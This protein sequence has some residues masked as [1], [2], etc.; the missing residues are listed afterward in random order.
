[1]SQEAENSANSSKDTGANQSVPKA[2]WR[3]KLLLLCV[4]TILSMLLAEGV[5][6]IA[7][8]GFPGFSVPQIEH[9]PA[10]GVGF[11]MIP[12]QQGFTFSSPVVVNSDGFRGPEIRERGSVDLRILCLGDSIT[13][14][15][16]VD[17]SMP[18]P[19][20]LEQLLLSRDES[21]TVEAINTGVQ[22]YYAYQEIDL[23]RQSVERL[24]PDVVTLGLYYNDLGIRPEGDYVKGYESEREQTASSFRKR[25]PK[26][27][28]L[29][30]NLAVIELSKQ[31]LLAYSK[32]KKYTAVLEGEPTPKEEKKWAALKEDLQAFQQ[33]SIEHGFQPVVVTIPSRVQVQQE[34]PESRFPSRALEFCDEFGIPAIDLHKHFVESFTAG[35]DPY[36]PWDNHMN[37]LGHR[38]VAEALAEKITELIEAPK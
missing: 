38:L 20:Q 10:E 32:G 14:G 15:V 17:E 13:F 12:D 25:A 19:R 35:E 37:P 9:R 24:K 21:R 18:Y 31:A 26:L 4:A 22:R 6:R 23:L 27:Y 30:K 1:M 5:V 7:K 33:L 28:L 2:T 16:G 11:E 34:F 3:R 36:L 29:I 8:P